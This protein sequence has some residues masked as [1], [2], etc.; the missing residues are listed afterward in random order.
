MPFGLSLVTIH[1]I[2]GIRKEVLEPFTQLIKSYIPPQAALKKRNKRRPDFQKFQHLKSQ[3]RKIDEK[4]A[5]QV[6]QYTALNDTLKL[7]LPKLSALNEKLKNMCLAR[8]I[9]IQAGWYSVWNEKLRT[10]L[11]QNELPKDIE[12]ILD[13]FTRDFKHQD[14]KAQ[15]MSILNGTLMSSARGRLSLSTATTKDDDTSMKSKSR[16]STLNDRGRGH[17]VHSDNHSSLA[18]PDPAQKNSGQYHFS[19]TANSSGLSLP[20]LNKRDVS[21]SVRQFYEGV[22]SLSAANPPY[23]GRP[24]TRLS[25][26]SGG[27]PRP[28]AES[29]NSGWSPAEAAYDPARWVDG[30]PPPEPSFSDVFNSALPWPNGNDDDRHGDWRSSQPLSDNLRFS[31]SGHRVL[32]VVASLNEFNIEGTKME[33]GYPYLKYQE[34]EVSDCS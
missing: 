20:Q 30:L 31:I 28:S 7:E 26:E 16:T 9:T 23:R 1:Q 11:E 10:V 5:E 14:A 2:S 18:S 15:S 12:D 8:L 19:P 25:F 34:G 17:S 29:T 6:E 3:N 21:P 27:V 33:G 32:F 22:D 13:K 4:L 24:D